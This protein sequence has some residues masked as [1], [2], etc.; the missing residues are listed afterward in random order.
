MLAETKCMIGTIYHE[1]NHMILGN[2]IPWCPTWLNEGLSEYFE[3]LNVIGENRRIYLNEHRAKWLR[4]WTRKGFPIKLQDYLKMNTSEWYT[5]NN[6][7]SG[8]G[9]ACSFRG[10]S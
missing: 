5:F 10:S 4:Y 9:Y 6:K 2:Q 3:G 7:N 1:A 8:A